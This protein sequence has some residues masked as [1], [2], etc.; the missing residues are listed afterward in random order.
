MPERSLH[1]P[2][3]SQRTALQR[4]AIARPLQA[5]VSRRL[6]TVRSGLTRL[7]R[8]LRVGHCTHTYTGYTQVS[9]RGQVAPR[10]TT[11]ARLG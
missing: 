6:G 10:E 7:P 4:R 9:L 1:C 11:R 5:Q 3:S 2:S 8:Q